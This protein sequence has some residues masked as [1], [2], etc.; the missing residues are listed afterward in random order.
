MTKYNNTDKI[1][2][3]K[4]ESIDPTFDMESMW[5]DIAPQIQPKRSR[6]G[7]FFWMFL[8]TFIV[9]ASALGYW[10]ISTDVVTNSEVLAEAIIENNIPENE[11][12]STS[13]SSIDIAKEKG[14]VV[15]EKTNTVNQQIEQQ[16]DIVN[17]TENSAIDKNISKNASNENRSMLNESETKLLSENIRQME[18]SKL[19]SKVNFDLSAI[20]KSTE[21]E[22]AIRDNYNFESVSSLAPLGVISTTAALEFSPLEME[23]NFDVQPQSDS[24]W[25]VGLNT[26]YYIHSR[27]FDAVGNEPSADFISRSSEEKAR[28]GYD[29]GLRLE[30]FI[31]DHFVLLGGVRYSKSYVERNADYEYTRSITLTD[32][33]IKIINTE[34]GPMEV[35]GDITYDGVFA[36]V[37][38]NYITASRLGIVAGMQ[39][40]VGTGR[41]TTHIDAGVELPVWSSHSG[42]ITND[43]APYNLANE[44]NEINTTAMQV[45]GGLGIE[46]SMTPT[47]ALQTTI[48]GYMPL[49]N[50]H[51][52]NYNIEKKSSLLGLSLGVYFRL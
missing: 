2:K 7:L 24:K 36:H 39:Y 15:A 48:G 22:G 35:L 12:Q 25:R 47:I 28:D 42:I 10:L 6:R 26:G 46:Y 16:E 51:V 43:G 3:S 38:N 11:D 45:F 23:E 41:W 17:V 52:S 40:R 37:A 13:L 1:I 32:H 9:G 21:S 50:E 5:T 14:P 29:L 33:V 19:R 8:S 27:S 34:Q 18:G 49:A 31:S 20:K 4:Y 30:Y 44:T